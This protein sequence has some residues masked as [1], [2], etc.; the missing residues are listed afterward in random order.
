MH[1]LLPRAPS[2][3]DDAEFGQ[4]NIVTVIIAFFNSASC[5]V[6]HSFVVL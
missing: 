4:R 6:F 1:A 5:L 2:T 3:G